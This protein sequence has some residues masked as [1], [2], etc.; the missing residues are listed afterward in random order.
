M[1]VFPVSAFFVLQQRVSCATTCAAERP[2]NF[3]VTSRL[4]LSIALTMPKYRLQAK[5]VGD[6]LERQQAGESRHALGQTACD[7]L[8]ASQHIEVFGLQ[9]A[10]EK[11]HTKID[12]PATATA[13]S[14]EAG[15]G[16]SAPR[17]HATLITPCYQPP[18]RWP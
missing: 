12:A 4:R 9:A 18:Q 5:V 17:C 7:P 13:C 15:P 1:G 16:S 8:V 6:V 3:R 14:P 2:A 10:P 11:G